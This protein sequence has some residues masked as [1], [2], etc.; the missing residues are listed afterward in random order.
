MPNI[1][2]HWLR[3]EFPNA[4][5]LTKFKERVGQTY[6]S[7]CKL[8]WIINPSAPDSYSSKII[9]EDAQTITYKFVT[10]WYVLFDYY[11]TMS[12]LFRNVKFY[13]TYEDEYQGMEPPKI[14]FELNVGDRKSELD[15]IK[16]LRE[17]SFEGRGNDNACAK[18]VVH[19]QNPLM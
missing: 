18:Y 19:L 5:E 13:V 12:Q 4:S 16:N 1:I 9:S 8:F 11:I 17:N 3:I 14:N 7:F 6:F 2:K 15:I 10:S